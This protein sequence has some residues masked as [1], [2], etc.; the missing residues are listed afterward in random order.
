MSAENQTPPTVNDVPT[1]N[2]MSDADKTLQQQLQENEHLLYEKSRIFSL[3]I[4]D[5]VRNNQELIG[6]KS[7][8]LTLVETYAPETSPEFSKKAVQLSNIYGHVRRVRGDGN[9]FYRS[10]LTAL[11]EKCLTDK[12]LLQQF[13]KL[14]GDWREKFF[15]MGFPELTTSDF[16]DS[17]DELLKN[18]ENGVYDNNSLMVTLGDENIANYYVAYIRILTSAF[19]RE[20]KDLYEGFIE[21]GRTME[22]F[23]LDEVEPMW[24]ECDHIT[25]IA[26]VNALKVNIRIEYM[27][28]SH[29]PEGGIHYDICG[30]DSPNSEPFLFFL[31]RPGHY[32]ILYKD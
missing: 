13:Q 3:Q 12:T 6:P 23:C 4:E 11:L 5:E 18:L 9:C 32:D 8:I 24:K 22:A 16:C 26:L 28:Q 29:S 19:L 1:N 20:N 25:I 30:S 31:Y 15:A 17:I 27:D 14:A 10:I 21:G 7:N 2:E